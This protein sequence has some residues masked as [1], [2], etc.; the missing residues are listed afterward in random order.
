MMMKLPNC[1]MNWI[2]FGLGATALV[3][4]APSVDKYW[5]ALLMGLV[6]LLGNAI[7]LLRK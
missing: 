2:G 6:A 5:I 1:W 7:E 3:I 4:A